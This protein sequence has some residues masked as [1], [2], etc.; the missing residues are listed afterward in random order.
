M[1]LAR[2]F[3]G[4]HLGV[5]DVDQ[6][7]PEQTTAMRTVGGKLLKNELEERIT[8]TKVLARAAAS[9]GVRM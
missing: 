4:L 3:P 8:F 9:G 6:L 1:W 5:D 2:Y 7:T